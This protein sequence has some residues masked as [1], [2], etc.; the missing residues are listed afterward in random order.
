MGGGEQIYRM[1][2]DDKIY[3]NPVPADYILWLGCMCHNDSHFFCDAETKELENE[4]RRLELEFGD[5]V[6]SD[7][8][9]GN[10]LR[11]MNEEKA[12]TLNNDATEYE[13]ESVSSD[14]SSNSVSSDESYSDVEI[15]I[16]K[17]AKKEKNVE[18]EKIVW[19]D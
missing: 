12:S 10:G 7:R 9:M 5:L 1:N 18:V 3:L 11:E 4:L 13:K 14:R 19:K 15:D 8:K 2:L 17:T 16:E 6:N